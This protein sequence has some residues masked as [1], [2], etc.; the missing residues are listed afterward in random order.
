MQQ[1]P[2]WEAKRS[3]ASQKIPYFYEIRRYI[4]TFTSAGHPFLSGAR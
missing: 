3:S 2:S 4:T 1:C